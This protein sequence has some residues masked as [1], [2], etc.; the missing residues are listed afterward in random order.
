MQHIPKIIKQI[1]CEQ[2][3]ENNIVENVNDINNI[4]KSIKFIEYTICNVSQDKTQIIF[5]QNLDTLATI[6]R[7]Q[8]PI[9]PIPP[10]FRTSRQAILV[11]RRNENKPVMQMWV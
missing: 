4:A 7:Q 3:I 8:Y 1:I 6:I 10:I 9:N 5:A 11:Y 2:N